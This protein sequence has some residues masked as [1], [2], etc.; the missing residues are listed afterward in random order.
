MRSKRGMTLTELLTV[1]AII[2][3]LIS[4][5]LPALALAMKTGRQTVC[6]SNL[7]QMGKAYD[8]Y[9]ANYHQRYPLAYYRIS[10]NPNAG[11]YFESYIA[12]YLTQ[13]P[14]V[15][16]YGGAIASRQNAVMRNSRVLLCPQAWADHPGGHA[17]G[18]FHTYSANPQFP[19]YVRDY[20]LP[21]TSDPLPQIPPEWYFPDVNLL[22]CP[23]A[24]CLVGDGY[25]STHVTPHYWAATIGP[26]MPPGWIY[27]PSFVPGNSTLAVHPGGDNILFA[28]Y[29]A[30]T[31]PA[32]AIPTVSH[33]VL[34][35][36]N[37]TGP[38]LDSWRFWM[39]GY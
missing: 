8:L 15:E 6:L 16:A 5:L 19:P 7:R 36:N 33:A 38:E 22:V 17:A 11:L 4:L 21:S 3:V 37:T 1:A 20:V 26:G 35:N 10:W 32:A 31:L 34:M 12:Q 13:I 25:Y 9:A 39:G 24:T 18:N 30:A 14:G 23:G 29:H 27:G 2:A 28:D